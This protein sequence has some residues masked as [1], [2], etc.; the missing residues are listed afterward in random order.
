MKNGP[1]N[2]SLL[3]DAIKS[4]NTRL[5]RAKCCPVLRHS[6]NRLLIG[7]LPSIGFTLAD[8]SEVDR[9]PFLPSASQSGKSAGAHWS[10]CEFCEVRQLSYKL[11]VS[12]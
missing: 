1:S 3:L 7:L 6:H 5:P 12:G 9:S 8:F 10:N 4:P 11:C 2:T